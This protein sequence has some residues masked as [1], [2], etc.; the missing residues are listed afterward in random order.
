MSQDRVGLADQTGVV[1]IIRFFQDTK[2][3]SY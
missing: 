2:L 1:V 3:L